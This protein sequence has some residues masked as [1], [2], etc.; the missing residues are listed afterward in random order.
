MGKKVSALPYTERDVSWMYFN[1]RILQEA[2]RPGVPLLERLSFLGIYSNNLDEF[3]RVRVAS[4][5]RVNE[6]GDKVAGKGSSRSGG[7]VEKEAQ[8]ARKTVKAISRLN[9]AYSKEYELAVESVYREYRI[10]AAMPI[11]FTKEPE[12]E[13]DGDVIEFLSRF[14]EDYKDRT[15]SQL[16]FSTHMNGTPWKK[17]YDDSNRGQEIPF[18][19]IIEMECQ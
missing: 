12:H 13:L 10:F 4:L 6:W 9:S 8:L 17:H 15:A 5:N 3:F 11:T 18:Q 19:D 16:V 1:R 2:E 7:A 14:A